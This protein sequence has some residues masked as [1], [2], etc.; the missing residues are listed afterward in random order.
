ME[1]VSTTLQCLASETA[2][3][4]VHFLYVNDRLKVHFSKKKNKQ[5]T[6]KKTNTTTN[7]NG[8]VCI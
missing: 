1:C 6:K 8:P 4:V 7:N 3:S 2:E 5:K